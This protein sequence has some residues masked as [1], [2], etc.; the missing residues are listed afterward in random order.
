MKLFQKMKTEKTLDET[1]KEYLESQ[2]APIFIVHDLY[3]AV[4]AGCNDM[5]PRQH[6][7]AVTWAEEYISNKNKDLTYTLHDL[8]NAYRFG[9]KKIAELIEEEMNAIS[10]RRR[11]KATKLIRAGQQLMTLAESF[12]NEAENLLSI[13]GLAKTIITN[14]WTELKEI[15]KEINKGNEK[16]FYGLSQKE[17]IK[18]GDVNEKIEYAVRKA[19]KIDEFENLENKMRRV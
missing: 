13:D 4:I 7:N 19:M 11:E 2:V 15:F 6:D 1:C 17:C 8:E 18:W 3:K 5:T 16:F 10:K 9:A 12:N 14:K